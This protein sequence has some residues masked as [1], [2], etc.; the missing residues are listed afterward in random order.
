MEVQLNNCDTLAKDFLALHSPREI[1]ELLEIPYE[2][3]NYHLYRTPA[4]RQYTT[5]SIPK[6]SG[7]IREICA[8]VT[9]IKIIQKK[10]NKIL[11]N[12]CKKTYARKNIVHGFIYGKNIRTN[13]EV[14]KNRE[15]VFNIDLMN[16]FPSI[17]FGRVYGMFK[18]KPYK[19]PKNVAAVLARIC[20]YKDADTDCLPQGAP[21]SPIISNMICER[22]D[23]ELFRFARRF[24]CRYTRYADDI[25]FSTDRPSFPEELAIITPLSYGR[26]LTAEVG[27]ELKD[28]IEGNWFSINKKKVRIQHRNCRQE[29]TGL[30]VNEFPNVSR[31]Y[32]N[33]I[34]AMLYA[35]G[36]HGLPAAEKE[37]LEK[38]DKREHW[39]FEPGSLFR[40]VVKGKLDFLKMVRG[41]QNATFQKFCEKLSSVDPTFSFIKIITEAEPERLQEAVFVLDSPRGQGTAFM[42]HGAGLVTSAHNVVDDQ[43]DTELYKVETRPDKLKAMVRDIRP[44]LDIAILDV[45]RGW[46]RASLARGDSSKL[47][48]G[49][50]VKVV[51]FPKYAPGKTI[52]IHKGSVTGKGMWFGVETINID[53]RIIDGNSGGPVLN[54]RNEVVGIAFYGAE[55]AEATEQKESGVIPI[56]LVDELL[57]NLGEL[58]HQIPLV[59]LGPDTPA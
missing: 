15:F 40:N 36:E 7:G 56:N 28:I 58:K 24:E 43:N 23:N 5:F 44:D 8:P 45:K 6:K 48:A 29:V 53:A 51:G 35:W 19:L 54:D 10:L 11:Q 49:D 32:T 4:A 46:A 12:V 33:Q 41:C 38:Y 22:M 31:K 55:S 57:E 39:P 30:I 42:L 18:G 21:T 25:T 3:L 16:F 27:G 34:R 26:R 47:R 13:A 1:A 50:A 9:A 59:N 14:H 2:V 52:Q 17:N 20:C 37:F